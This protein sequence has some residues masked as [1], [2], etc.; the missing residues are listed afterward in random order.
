VSNNNNSDLTYF[1]I[2][3]KIKTL[4]S[5]TLKHNNQ[6]HEQPSSQLPCWSLT[7]TFF[8]TTHDTLRLKWKCC[9]WS[10]VEQ[11][12]CHQARYVLTTAAAARRDWK[13]T[14]SSAAH[15]TSLFSPWP[16]L[17]NL[18]GNLAWREIDHVTDASNTM[19][20]LLTHFKHMSAYFDGC[21]TS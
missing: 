15:S 20:T 21:N 4:T 10:T 19:R 9:C 18:C 5:H 14:P 7:V 3:N 8:G 17:Q 6:S 1:N 16:V 11:P 13:P 12:A 2:K